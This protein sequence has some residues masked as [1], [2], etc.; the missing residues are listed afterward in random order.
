MTGQ[1]LYQSL[2]YELKFQKALIDEM[3]ED[4][5]RKAN[6]ESDYYIAKYNTAMELHKQGMAVTLINTIIKGHPNVA[7][8]LKEFRVSETIYD[9]DKSAQI[10][11]QNRLRNLEKQI[12][13]ERRG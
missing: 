11:C 3:R 8:K 6:A 2:N 12:E 4:G 1:D 7:Q 9:A 10:A 13:W 5:H